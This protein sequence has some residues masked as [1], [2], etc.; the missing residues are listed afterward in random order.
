LMQRNSMYRAR[1]RASLEQFLAHKDE[2][3]ARLRAATAKRESAQLQTQSSARI[4][5]HAG[6]R[7]A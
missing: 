3:L 2:E 6:V 7:N 1:E 4:G 5:S